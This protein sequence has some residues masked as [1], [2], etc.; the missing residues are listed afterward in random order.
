MWAPVS[1]RA[2]ATPWITDIV[3]PTTEPR[4]ERVFTWYNE[5]VSHNNVLHISTWAG[6]HKHTHEKERHFK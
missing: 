6:T 1:S 4:S 5:T 3:Y 2:S